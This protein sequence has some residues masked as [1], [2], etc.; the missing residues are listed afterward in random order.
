[1]NT[2]KV[3]LLQNTAPGDAEPGGAGSTHAAVNERLSTGNSRD[4]DK[5]THFLYMQILLLVPE[6]WE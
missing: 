4:G 3:S 6:S 5:Q 1:M 2:E